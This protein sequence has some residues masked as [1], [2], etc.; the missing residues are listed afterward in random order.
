MTAIRQLGNELRGPLFGYL[1]HFAQ[2]R[3]ACMGHN[4]IDQTGKINNAD[5]QNSYVGSTEQGVAPGASGSAVGQFASISGMGN[6]L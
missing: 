4:D 6:P 5:D 2:P 3:F 1:G